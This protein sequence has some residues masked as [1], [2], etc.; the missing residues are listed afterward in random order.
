MSWRAI[1]DTVPESTSLAALTH[2]AER[3]YWRLVSQADPWGLL[4]G[5]EPKIRARCVPL[6]SVSDH[7]L[8]E[9][10]EELVRAGRIILYLEQG[11]WTCEITD[12]DRNQP[13]DIL[14]RHGR[15]FTSRWPC[16]TDSSRIRGESPSFG[17]TKRPAL[18]GAP[19]GAGQFRERPAESESESEELAANAAM[20]ASVPTTTP[21][22][23]STGD[24]QATVRR[25]YDHWRQ[26]RGKRDPR[27]DRVSEERRRKIR[28]R[29]REFSE[30][31][32]FRALDAVALD[33]WPERDRHDDLTKLFQSREKVDRW[34]EIADAS[35]SGSN[36]EKTLHL[37]RI[38]AGLNPYTGEPEGAKA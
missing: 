16:R 13:R 5:T 11:V 24:D 14:G 32:L 21:G 26:V 25:V 33:D 1:Q 31:D 9:A 36:L 29:L 37:E 7:E 34:L 6:L 28:S 22:S 18:P 10:L 30:Q 19:G 15:R 27:Y 4:P 20:S 35:E 3:L 23:H 12:W 8:T 17:M 2:F 38:R